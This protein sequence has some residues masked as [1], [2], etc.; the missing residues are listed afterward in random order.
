ML[1]RIDENVEIDMSYITCAEYQLFIDEK[2]ETGEHRQP[3]HWTSYRFPPG[4][5]K[6]S[7]IGIRFS[8]AEEFCEWLNQQQSPLGFKYRLP[9]LAEVE[10]SPVAEK[11]VGCWCFD[12][13]QRMQVTK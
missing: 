13:E 5:A 7:I 10:E 6:K 3:D 1:L 11:Q 2:L 4:D 9:T 12:G 8:D